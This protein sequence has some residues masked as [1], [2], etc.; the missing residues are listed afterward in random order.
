MSFNSDLS[1]ILYRTCTQAFKMSPT[2]NI[3]TSI[4]KFMRSQWP[5]RRFSVRTC[6]T[7]EVN[8]ELIETLWG[9]Y[10]R[11]IFDAFFS[12]GTMV[13]STPRGK[14]NSFP[15][16][17]TLQT[18][19]V[20]LMRAMFQAYCQVL[21]YC[22]ITSLVPLSLPWIVYVFLI[23]WWYFLQMF[24][25]CFPF[26]INQYA[27]FKDLHSCLKYCLKVLPSSMKTTE[28]IPKLSTTSD[29]KIYAKLVDILSKVILYITNCMRSH[30]KFIR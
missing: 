21:A 24:H 25:L 20:P 26:K 13:I 2:C 28:Q 29:M 19:Y 5:V 17:A 14:Q 10:I 22:I 3:G 30:I 27:S 12:S 9:Y 7:D 11:A 15:T 16:S 18:I 23:K 4:D 6:S 8:L 1:Y